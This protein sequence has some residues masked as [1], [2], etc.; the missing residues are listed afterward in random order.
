MTAP[1]RAALNQ[2]SD[3]LLWVWGDCDALTLLLLCQNYMT[4][5]VRIGKFDR[6]KTSC[7]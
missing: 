2:K 7:F 4:L 6:L 5:C 3:R 1:H